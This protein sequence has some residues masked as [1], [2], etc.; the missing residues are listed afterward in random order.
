MI[1]INVLHFDGSIQSYETRE[2][3]QSSKKESGGFH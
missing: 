3:H 1:Q 2:E